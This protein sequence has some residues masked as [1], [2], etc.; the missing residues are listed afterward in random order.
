MAGQALLVT[1]V[2]TDKSDPPSRAE[3]MHQLTRKKAA[4]RTAEMDRRWSGEG[5]IPTQGVGTINT[6]AQE[7]KR[8]LP[9]PLP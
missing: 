2:A 8:S 1:F 3:P 5:S 6:T 9:N 7:L 4:A